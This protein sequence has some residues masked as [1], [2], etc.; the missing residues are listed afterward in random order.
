MARYLTPWLLPRLK[1]SLILLPG[2]PNLTAL[3]LPKQLVCDCQ[4]FQRCVDPCKHIYAVLFRFRLDVLKDPKGLQ[5]LI[6]ARKRKTQGVPEHQEIRPVPEPE[7]E[8]TLEL[9]CP[10]PTANLTPGQ[11]S[12]RIDGIVSELRESLWNSI[13]VLDSVRLDNLQNLVSHGVR[14]ATETANPLDPRGLIEGRNAWYH[15][16]SKTKRQRR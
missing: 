12:S 13:D 16:K 2:I 6:Q 8:L 5:D 11:I 14:G 9:T 4:D 15:Q 1:T 7:P 10:E 3:K